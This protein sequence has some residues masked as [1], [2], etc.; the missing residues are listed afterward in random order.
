[1]CIYV[2]IVRASLHMYILCVRY[3]EILCTWWRASRR[4]FRGIECLLNTYCRYTVSIFYLILILVLAAIYNLLLQKLI[5][6]FSFARFSCRF[7]SIS[8]FSSSLAFSESLLSAC[9]TLSSRGLNWG[10]CYDHYFRRFSQIFGEIIGTSCF[11]LAYVH[12]SKT[13]SFMPTPPLG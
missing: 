2:P 7:L 13:G 4:D 10:Q 8:A 1:M 11:T 6:C 12:A 9:R 5:T 3:S